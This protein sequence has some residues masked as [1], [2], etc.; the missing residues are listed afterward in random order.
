M[1]MPIESEVTEV[2]TDKHFADWESD[3]FGYGYGTGEPHTLLA[4]K[5]FFNACEGNSSHRYD[6]RVVEAMIGPVPAWLLINAL[7][8]ADI[9]EYG[10]SPRFGWLTPKGRLL[11]T[12][13]EPKTIEELCTICGAADPMGHCS[14]DNCN[15]ETPCNNPLF[16]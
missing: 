8:H 9:I 10:T 13:I 11:Y 3:V 16:R 2:V 14:P 5:N 7:C 1:T 4:L 15:C 12:Y 6:H